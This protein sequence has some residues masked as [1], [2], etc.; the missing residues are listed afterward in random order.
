MK[1]S[2]DY[3]DR[4]RPTSIILC[5]PNGEELYSL[6]LA[7][8]IELF[9]S[10]DE[11]STLN[12]SIEKCDEE[13]IPYYDYLETRRTIKVDGYGTYIITNVETVSEGIIEEKRVSCIGLEFE[14]SSKQMGCEGTYK[15]YDL[16][17]NSNTII[18]YIMS[19]IPSWS[20]EHVD[21]E[22]YSVYRTF[23]QTETNLYNF[24]KEEVE[25]AY[26]CIFMFNTDKKTISVKKTKNALYDTDIYLS[27]RNIIKQLTIN[28]DA[29]NIFTALNVYGDG[30]LN[31]ASV[32]PLGTTTIYNFTH[33]ATEK[34]MGKELA[35]K[36]IAWQ[37][38]V[39][40]AYETFG[41]LLVDI[42][43]TNQAI[44]K[45]NADKY[46]IETEKKALEQRLHLAVFNGSSGS[47]INSEI[48]KVNQRLQAKQQEIDTLQVEL[49]QKLDIKKSINNSLSFE[50]NFTK[51]ENAK[52]STFIYQTTVVN[53]NYTQTDLDSVV[54]IQNMMEELYA[55]GKEE[56]RK[57]SQPIYT[58][59]IDVLDFLK[60]K[61]FKKYVDQIG[62]GAKI[63]IE[64]DKDKYIEAILLSY[65]L[66]LNE[67]ESNITLNFSNVFNKSSTEFTWEELFNT[68]SSLSSQ[69]DFESYKYKQGAEA[70]SMINEYIN[71]AL[72]LSKQEILASDNQ[73]FVMNNLGIR[74]REF[75]PET[76]NY[77]GE[78]I[79]ITKNIIAFSDDGFN[80]VKQAI[81]KITLPDGNKGYGIIADHI[82]G[83]IMFTSSLVCENET[84]SFKVDGGNVT[85]KNGNILMTTEDG[86][87]NIKDYIDSSTNTVKQ[88]LDKVI[89]DGLINTEKLSGSILAGKN[90]IKC[91]D[92]NNMLLMNEKGILI[93]KDG[94]ATYDTA[95]SADGVYANHIKAGTNI[96]GCKFISKSTENIMTLT[97]GQ[98]RFKS[99][100]NINSSSTYIER[101]SI[102]LFSDN[103]T[104]LALYA[105]EENSLGKGIIINGQLYNEEMFVIGTDT[106][107]AS[108]TFTNEG[109]VSLCAGAGNNNNIYI[110]SLTSSSTLVCNIPFECTNDKS[111]IVPT[112]HYGVRKLYCD[113]SDRSY[114]STKGIG[115][116]INGE[117]EIKLDD[118]FIEVIELNSS[119]PYIIQLT[120]YGDGKIWVE[121]VEDY[122][123]T[124]KGDKDISFAYDLKAI[125]I[126][127]GG[128]YLEERKNID[129]NI[130]KQTQIECI[131]RMS[132]I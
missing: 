93:S 106:S 34:W 55:W 121:R 29:S 88:E 9:V 90:N 116:L 68:T 87:K 109:A 115:T 84:G 27:D 97:D 3:F 105:Y 104:T 124:I 73:E 20:I 36:V 83:R 69:F 131:N 33:Y 48:A 67:I 91:V 2:Y 61:E 125:R 53:D 39:D 80:T 102:G 74:G 12:F 5:N 11:V 23:E 72:D 70:K 62:R 18:G 86:D 63:T 65:Q 44:I 107:G 122:S 118:P 129:K 112:Q 103:N 45:G 31:I 46:D 51:E 60:I 79:W 94:G 43:N 119:Y 4:V 50:N 95:I 6:A 52:L 26:D 57:Q 77:S 42:K 8:D 113:E 117:C 24:I 114:F 92:S 99:A 35:D 54:D 81:G 7:K 56:L 32:N 17:D 108:I 111:A 123:F 47:D 132:N 38:K 82:I 98:I 128:V 1:V 22:L 30:D 130:L 58:F 110:D 71:N 59:S 85:I 101:N 89:V 13:V 120:P 25:K 28:E 100:T 96:E 16:T 40:E 75:I 37:K 66:T 64:V 41:E 19:Y 49:T 76:G 21:P 126:S 127:F 78:Q 14:L 15:F 10:L